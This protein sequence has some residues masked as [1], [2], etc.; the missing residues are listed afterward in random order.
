MR[1]WDSS[2]LV[3]LVVRQPA[4]PEAERWIADDS[5][6][7]T[8]TLTPVE[9]LSA[10]RRLVRD[11]VLADRAAH[12]VEALAKTLLQRCHVVSD[13]ERVKPVAMRLLRVHALRAADALQ[14][15]AALVWSDGPPEAA[16]L[17]TFDQRLGGAAEREGFRVMPA[18]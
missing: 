2:A 3:P 16:V 9:V 15:A 12:D 6:V 1:F 8:W 17:H 4:S 14:L 7:V 13:V 10:L 11:G 18:P 5:A